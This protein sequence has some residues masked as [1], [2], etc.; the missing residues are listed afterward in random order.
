LADLPELRRGQV[1]TVDQTARFLEYSPETK[2]IVVGEENVLS[3]VGESTTGDCQ[4]IRLMAMALY[5]VAG[6]RPVDPNWDRRGRNV[7]QYEL[8]VKRLDV[9]FDERLKK[10]FEGALAKGL[11]KGAAAVHDPTSYWATGVTAYFDAAGQ[12]AA[13][14][15]AKHP[16]C[17]REALQ[18]YDAEL[19]A[20]VEETMAYT[21][22]VDWRYPR[23]PRD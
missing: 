20:L 15:D 2:L 8:R 22:H 23:G 11:W 7:Q 4:V 3:D 18:Q 6:K 1:A 21:G 16:I 9:Q 13:P 19:F 14:H 5:E 10:S 17:T 12:T